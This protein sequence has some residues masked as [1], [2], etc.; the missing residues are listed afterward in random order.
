MYFKIHKYFDSS[1]RLVCTVKCLWEQNEI[2]Y[3][4]KGEY[5]Y[6][7]AVI[8]DDGLPSVERQQCIY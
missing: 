7:L 1:K 2:I 4:K 5:V 8:G 3:R 6:F